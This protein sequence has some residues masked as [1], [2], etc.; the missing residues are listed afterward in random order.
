MPVRASAL[1]LLLVAGCSGILGTYD[2]GYT[3]HFLV[4]ADAPPGRPVE[5]RLVCTVGH[6]AVRAVPETLSPHG[7]RAF[8]V[9]RVDAQ[10]GRHRISVWD[11][12]TRADERTDV[13]LEHETWVIL[14]I[15]PKDLSTRL[16]VFREP[17]GSEIGT[18]RSLVPLPD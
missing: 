11:P 1:F 18:W 14:E 5:T 15:D 8:E 2:P 9:A 16:R 17:P 10:P 7:P 6:H 12:A 13:D 3:V 4:L